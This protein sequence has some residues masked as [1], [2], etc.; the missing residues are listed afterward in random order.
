MDSG[1]YFFYCVR[2]ISEVSGTK[3]RVFTN[4]VEV[5]DVWACLLS[6]LGEAVRDPTQGHK[7]FI[8]ECIDPLHSAPW[9]PIKPEPIFHLLNQGAA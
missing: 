7:F 9:S 6:F 2:K 5:N 8:F 1:F 3:V 4:Y